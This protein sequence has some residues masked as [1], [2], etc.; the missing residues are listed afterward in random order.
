MKDRAWLLTPGIERLTLAGLHKLAK[1]A[2]RAGYAPPQLLR[3]ADCVRFLRSAR[4]QEWERLRHR[5]KGPRRGCEGITAD[6]AN[7]WL[8]TLPEPKVPHDEEV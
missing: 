4:D 2:A 5:P 1:G 3:K 6:E 8:R 7:A